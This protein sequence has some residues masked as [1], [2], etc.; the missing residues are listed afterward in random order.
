MTPNESC[1]VR[2][3]VTATRLEDPH[4]LLELCGEW[5]RFC[6]LPVR[7]VAVTVNSCGPMGMYG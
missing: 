6:L 5:Q 2:R 1:G 4:R 3:S 7:P